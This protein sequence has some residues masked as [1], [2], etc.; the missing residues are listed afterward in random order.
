MSRLVFVQNFGCQMNDY[1]VERMV[2]VLRKEGYEATQ[3]ADE[4]D[5]ILINSCS[6]REKAE[7]K[8]ASAAGRFRELKQT[9]PGLLVAIGGC[10]AQQEG[11]RLLRRAP[12]ADFTF[13]PNQIP[14]LCGLVDRPLHQRPRF[15]ATQS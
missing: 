6:V 9:R 10:V 8:V 11:P 1:D 13:A 15:S 2:E 3:R 7:Q 14:S 12:A 5:L 4:A